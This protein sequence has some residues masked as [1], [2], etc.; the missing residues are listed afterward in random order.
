[1]APRAPGR[2]P[3]TPEKSPRTPEKSPRTPEKSPRAEDS[4]PNILMTE[5]V[6]SSDREVISLI[7][8]QVTA[9]QVVE[10]VAPTFGELDWRAFALHVEKACTFTAENGEKFTACEYIAFDDTTSLADVVAE[11]ARHETKMD[12]ALE[13]RLFLHLKLWDERGWEARDAIHRYLCYSRARQRFEG[14]EVLPSANEVA[15]LA[16][17]HLFVRFGGLP[18]PRLTPSEVE[19]AV[20]QRFLSLPERKWEEV[21]REEYGKLKKGLLPTTAMMRAMR[22]IDSHHSKY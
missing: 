18:A 9:G 12:Q 15:H 3:H 4:T 21:V 6:V 11:V 17:L 20:P 2:E 16:A 13:K 14:G 19:R 10:K 5:Q 22:I 7:A 8:N 1:G